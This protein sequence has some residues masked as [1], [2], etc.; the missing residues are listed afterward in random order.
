MCTTRP[1]YLISSCL[2]GLCTRYDQKTKKYPIA[3]KELENAIL[4]PVCPEQLG[5]LPTPRDAADLIGGDGDDVLDH[6]ALVVTRNG[7]DVTS[8]FTLGA[9]QTLKVA[10]LLGVTKALLKARSPSCGVTGN[11]G[12]TAALL[13]KNNIETVEI[14]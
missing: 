2:L 4:I 14:D 1:V 11:K 5:G 12:V 7:V 8:E 3:E 9:E 10:Q 6:N 13:Q